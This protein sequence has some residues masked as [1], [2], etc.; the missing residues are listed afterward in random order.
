MIIR[1]ANGSTLTIPDGIYDTTTSLPLAG[2]HVVNYTDCINSQLLHLTEHF[3]DN[4]PPLNAVVGQLWYNSGIK[5]LQVLTTNGW[6]SLGEYGAPT[7]PSGTLLASN[8]YTYLQNY[9]Q[10]NNNRMVGN[11]KVVPTTA[12][13]N[14]NAVVTKLFVDS[15]ATPTIDG[16]IPLSGNHD[17]PIRTIQFKDTDG[18][19]DQYVINRNY[20]D[21]H[22]ANTVKYTGTLY[23][24]GEISCKVDV[25]RFTQSKLT[26]IMGDAIL[27]K[28]KKFIRVLLNSLGDLTMQSYQ[29]NVYEGSGDIIITKDGPNFILT[30]TSATSELRCYFTVVGISNV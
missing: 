14:D 13:I 15:L 9:L 30:R 26:Y 24:D 27:A 25:V 22:Y 10:P 8:V 6:Q 20:A 19:N 5:K 1:K 2:R 21:T 29:V 11:L 23:S 28:N 7:T 4:L 17:T 3:N 16:Y 18:T 12:D